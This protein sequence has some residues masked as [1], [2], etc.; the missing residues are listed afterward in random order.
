[1]SVRA[2]ATVPRS[3]T[4]SA[5]VV[6]GLGASASVARSGYIP[7][8]YGGTYEFEATNDEQIVETAGK[9][10]TQDIHIAP[11]PR[12]IGYVYYSGSILTIV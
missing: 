5:S 8:Y 10:L 2:T 7:D 6:R 9:T 12:N 11:L 3:L 1:M 4:A